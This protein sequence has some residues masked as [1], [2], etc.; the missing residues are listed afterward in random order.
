MQGASPSCE[1]LAVSFHF[2]SPSKVLDIASMTLFLMTLD[3]NYFGQ[4]A[5]TYHNQEF[6]DTCEWQ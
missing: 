1:L 6:P 2:H 5:A 4:G 3:C